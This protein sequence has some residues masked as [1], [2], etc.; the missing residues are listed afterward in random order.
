MPIRNTLSKRPTAKPP[1][2]FRVA[3]SFPGEHRDFVA[4]VAVSLAENLG[5]T[6]VLYDA[7]YEAEFARPNLDTYLQAIYHDESDLIAVFLCADYA[8]KDWCGLEWRALR[9]L[10]KG[11]RGESVMPLR[12]DDT[13]ITGLFSIDGYCWIGNRSPAQI[14]GLILERLRRIDPT[15]P[16]PPPPPPNRRR[17]LVAAAGLAAVAGLGGGLAWWRPWLAPQQVLAG[18]V[19]NGAGDRLAGARVAVPELGLAA[20]T[21]PDGYFTLRVR[22]EPGRRVQIGVTR[23]GYRTYSDLATLGNTRLGILL[24]PVSP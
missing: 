24:Q 3:L 14:A 1:K 16:P 23:D 19:S 10:I 7:W 15:V 8:R 11:R 13:E 4:Q 5:R 20:I 12:L 22:A 21:D 9:D 18:I 2:R 17:L 6:A